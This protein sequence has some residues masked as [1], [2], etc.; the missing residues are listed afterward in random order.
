MVLILLL[1]G[2]KF[3][4]IITRKPNGLIE[5]KETSMS[6]TKTKVSYWYYNTELWMKS[7]H[8]KEND[9]TDRCMTKGDIEWVQKYYI[10]KLK[11]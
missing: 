6:F 7:S 8:G 11:E 1:I 9:V 3:M 4:L 2:V 10:P 5:V